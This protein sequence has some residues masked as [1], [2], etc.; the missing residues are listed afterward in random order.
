MSRSRLCSMFG[1]CGPK[2]TSRSGGTAKS[3]PKS[4]KSSNSRKKTEFEKAH[5]EE[6]K[7]SFVSWTFMR[8][9]IDTWCPGDINALVLPYDNSNQFRGAYDE[10]A[11]PYEALTN[12]ARIVGRN[13]MKMDPAGIPQQQ[14][15]EKLVGVQKLKLHPDIEAYFKNPQGLEPMY[16]IIDNTGHAT[17]YIVLRNKL[18]SMGFGFNP[19]RDILSQ[20][21]VTGDL[22][23]LSPDILVTPKSEI[24]VDE[25]K[26]NVTMPYRVNDAGFFTREHKDKLDSYLRL[27]KPDSAKVHYAEQLLTSQEE[28]VSRI[29]DKE[30]TAE[31]VDHMTTRGREAREQSIMKNREELA[32]II[33]FAND[34]DTT[35]EGFMHVMQNLLGRELNEDEF[36]LVALILNGG[37]VRFTGYYKFILDQ[38]YSLA[39]NTFTATH[40]AA[41]CTSALQYIFRTLDCTFYKTLA[42]PN[43]C[44]SLRLQ[45]PNGTKLFEYV[46]SYFHKM[47]NLKPLTREEIEVLRGGRVKRS[48]R[49]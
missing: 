29:L 18:Y 9:V 47:N 48:R 24:Y 28:L 22:T 26:Q 13:F 21:T 10:Q 12:N 15:R 39:S 25:I 33:N 42:N 49:K 44:K 19:G 8:T 36:E 37:R 35:H 3:T 31:H 43:N 45:R 20:C 4:E 32:A 16:M 2:E 5:F 17:L 46:I 6:E 1:L 14:T 30:Y 41:N 7:E 27:Y 23:I 40:G 34:P 11:T 38:K